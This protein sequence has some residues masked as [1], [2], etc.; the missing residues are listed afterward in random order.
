MFLSPL[1]K[2]YKKY[3][4]MSFKAS[5]IVKQVKVLDKLVP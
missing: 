4:K 2:Y 5:V 3:V 1:Y